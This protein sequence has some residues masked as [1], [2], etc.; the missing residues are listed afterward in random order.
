[1]TTHEHFF[2][3]INAVLTSLISC[4]LLFKTVQI[5]LMLFKHF[6]DIVYCWKYK[7]FSCN[8]LLTSY[9]IIVL[10]STTITT[11]H[12]N[13]VISSKQENESLI[14]L[15]YLRH[16]KVKKIF[17]TLTSILASF[18]TTSSFSCK[19][20]RKVSWKHINSYNEF[21]YIKRYFNHN[22]RNILQDAEVYF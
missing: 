20:C 18:R 21:L 5:F 9:F 15:G 1:M 4:L 8:C 3:L 22:R 17:N 13:M 12:K 16:L 11:Q 10:T 2:N 19:A 6:R 7:Q 14:T